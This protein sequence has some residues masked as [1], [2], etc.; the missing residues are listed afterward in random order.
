MKMRNVCGI[1]MKNMWHRINSH[2]KFFFS[3]FF[4]FVAFFPFYLLLFYGDDFTIPQPHHH[5]TW[6]ESENPFMRCRL[7]IQFNWILNIV[8]CLVKRGMNR[9][10]FG[11]ILCWQPKSVCEVWTSYIHIMAHNVPCA[12]VNVW[13]EKILV[14]FIV[15][16]EFYRPRRPKRERA[17]KR[18]RCHFLMSHQKCQSLVYFDH[19]RHS[20]S[21]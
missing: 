9:V 19:I 16:I 8:I 21:S 4:D 13:L 10:E 20:L 15:C 7:I 1:H 17:S 14:Y 18:K 5:L 3:F 2:F 6:I 11:V 12:I